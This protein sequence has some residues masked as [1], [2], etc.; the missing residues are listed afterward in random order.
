MCRDPPENN[1]VPT[2]AMRG[3]GCQRKESQQE[4]IK[5]IKLGYS[6]VLE[7]EIHWF[8]PVRDAVIRSLFRHKTG[9]Q[10]IA[11]HIRIL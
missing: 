9:C 3:A 10:S 6:Q 11:E 2:L 4:I 8:P 7:V 5:G 1:I